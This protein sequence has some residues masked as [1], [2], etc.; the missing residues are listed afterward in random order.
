MRQRRKFIGERLDDSGCQ[1]SVWATL[2][3]GGFYYRML[4]E[5]QPRLPIYNHV[6]SRESFEGPLKLKRGTTWQGTQYASFRVMR[7]LVPGGNVPT[8]EVIRR[9]FPGLN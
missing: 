8:V 6:V 1:K 4:P 2:P 9:D 7:R 5:W 3:E